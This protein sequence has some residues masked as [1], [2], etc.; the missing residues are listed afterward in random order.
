MS[1][2][3]N[4]AIVLRH[5]KGCP[6]RGA[7]GADRQLLCPGWIHAGMDTPEQWR[8]RVLWFHK[9]CPGFKM[10]ILDLMAEG[11]KVMVHLTTISPTQFRPTHRL[12]Y[13]SSTW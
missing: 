4:K 3:E 7:C 2:E 13:L 5:V 12:L 10:T 8:E 11:D 1:T 6:G 9:T